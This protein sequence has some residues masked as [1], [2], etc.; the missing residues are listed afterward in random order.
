MI[1]MLVVL[2]SSLIILNL[3]LDWNIVV[4]ENLEIHHLKA[5][6]T[7]YKWRNISIASEK[8][9]ISQQALS[10]KL[11]KMR[12]VFADPLFVRQGHG[13]VPTPYAQKILP[14]IDDVLGHL[15]LIPSSKD[16]KPEE[17][18]QVLT[19]SATD[20]LQEIVVS[21]LVAS[22]QKIAPLIKFVIVNIESAELLRKFSEGD[23]DMALTSEGYAPE[24]AIKDHLF[25]EDY[26]CVTSDPTLFSDSPVSI[27]DISNHKFIVTNPGMPSF[28]GSAYDW[29]NRKDISRE[30]AISSPSYAITKKLLKETSYLAFLPSRLLPEDGL[31]D[32]ELEMYPPGFQSVLTYHPSRAE[33]PVFLLVKK[34]IL[35]IASELI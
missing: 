27:V 6:Q 23:I 20:F 3:K 10:V 15:F 19:I 24:G 16:E 35:A 25:P 5:F 30:V 8:L 2:S 7:I 12:I 11:G 21:K 22:L 33:D 1:K 4:I 29:F 26:R 17:A 32:I 34:Q 14:Y 28:T 18:E 31:I 9:N 13:V